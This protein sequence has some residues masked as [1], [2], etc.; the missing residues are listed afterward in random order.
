[1]MVRTRRKNE[2]IVLKYYFDKLNFLILFDIMDQQAVSYIIADGLTDETIRLSA[3][4]RCCKTLEE[5]LID[6]N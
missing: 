1:M 3:K 5:L 6:W 4:A 2:M